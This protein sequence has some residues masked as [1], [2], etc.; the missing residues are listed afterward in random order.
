MITK[1]MS[2][3]SMIQT[4]HLHMIERII[5]NTHSLKKNVFS[6]IGILSFM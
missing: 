6:L 4:N 1:L 3:K 2:Y 5:E